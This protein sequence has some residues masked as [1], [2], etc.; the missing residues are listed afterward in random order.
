MVRLRPDLEF[1]IVTKRIV[2]LLDCVPEDWGGGYDNVTIICTVENQRQCDIRMP[3]FREL[4]VKRKEIIAEPLLSGIDMRPYL[5]F[6]ASVTVG[7]ESGQSARVCDYDWVLDIR[8]QCMAAE[9]DFFFKQT[10]AK[11]KKDGRIYRVPRK[12]QQVQARKASLDL[13][14]GET[15]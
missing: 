6:V 13:R 12:F 1:S 10:G 14:F 8:R 4:P 9:T 11:F 7:G 5:D 15:K 3:V 2:R